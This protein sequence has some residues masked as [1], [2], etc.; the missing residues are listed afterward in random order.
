MPTLLQ[1]SQSTHKNH[2]RTDCELS[3]SNCAVL[4]PDLTGLLFGRVG[5]D[6]A[7]LN[8]RKYQDRRHE[9]ILQYVYEH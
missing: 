4:S 6:F 7:S 1:A 5:I 9:K 3:S 8:W 2:K